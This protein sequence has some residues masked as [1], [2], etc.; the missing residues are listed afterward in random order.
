MKLKKNFTIYNMADEYMLIPT[1]ESMGSFGGT[2]ILNDVSAFILEQIK[3]ESKSREELL[4]A[5]LE[6]Y[7]VEKDVASADLDEAIKS[8]DEMD[9]LE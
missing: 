9:V 6:E 7:D 2:V 8:L 5:I 3:D 4:A 1:G